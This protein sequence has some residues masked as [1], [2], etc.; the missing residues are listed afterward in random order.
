M[1]RL[2]VL[3][4]DDSEVCR[5]VLRNIL[6]AD[7]DIWVTEEA[8][9]G[10]S[11]IR[12]IVR[13]KPNLA[14]IDIQMPGLDGLA[15]I[16]RIMAQ[17]PL[18][19][20]VVT[21]LPAGRGSDLVFQALRRGA[22]DVAEKPAGERSAAA[23]QLREQVRILS[24]VSVIKHIG[25]RAPSAAGSPRPIVVKAGSQVRVVGLGASAGGPLAV[26]SVLGA[27]PADFP[28][29]VALVQ[30]I[31]SGF[32]G[33]LATFL[34]GVTKL[35]VQIV[36]DRVQPAPGTVLIATDDRHLVAEAGGRF[37]AIDT[38]PLGGHRPSVNVLFGS[39]A[40]VFG[41]QTAGVV[42]TGIGDD[43]AVGLAEMRAQGAVTIAQDKASSAVYGMPK[44]AVEKNAASLVLP[45]D[46][47]ALELVR[48]VGRGAR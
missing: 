30:H 6:E 5:T 15:V 3:I 28:A 4:A 25:L 46:Q 31:P 35:S 10:E 18:P 38:P 20:L 1:K 37:A 45:L 22:L 12:S 24:N 2:E 11:A 13:S 43:G 36:S 48:L 32:A 34:R 17:H 29:C 41:R 42:L 27:L 33:P 7:G 44:A 19:I 39:L 16:E 14:T 8:A 9:D 40:K 23:R 26:A 47:I 21:G